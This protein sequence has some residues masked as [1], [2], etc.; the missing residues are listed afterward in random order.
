MEDKTRPIVL[1]V[2]KRGLESV[3]T[4]IRFM[5]WFDSLFYNIKQRLITFLYKH[6]LCSKLPLPGRLNTAELAGMGIRLTDEQY[7]MLTT[8]SPVHIKHAQHLKQVQL[9][10]HPPESN[11]IDL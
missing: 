1:V 2:D 9:N 11:N 8:G 5:S 4:E 7:G 6:N 10:I 3:V